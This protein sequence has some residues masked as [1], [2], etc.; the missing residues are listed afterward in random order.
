MKTFWESLVTKNPVLVLALGLVP[1]VA[2]ATTVANGLALGLITAAV[3]LV[4]SMINCVL[5]SV[6]PG[7]S[8]RILE[9]LVMVAL[10]VAVYSVLLNT[11]PA[12]IARLGI[13]LPLVAANTLLL[14]DPLGKRPFGTVLLETLGK[15][16]GFTLAL[17]VIGVIRE[18]L[19]QGAVFGRQVVTGALPPMSLASGVPGGLIIVGLLMA[20]VNKISKRG[21]ELHD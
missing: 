5:V 19:G 17:V 21:G 3:L 13:F 4:A 6:M 11:D 16:L 18:F 14:Q 10:V 8:G 9:R 20:L 15:G 1:A 7:N 2:I 12:L